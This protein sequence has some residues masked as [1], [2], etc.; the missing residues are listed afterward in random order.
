MAQ[1]TIAIQNLFKQWLWNAA[2][3]LARP[4]MTMNARFSN[5]PKS[6]KHLPGGKTNDEKRQSFAKAAEFRFWKKK[7]S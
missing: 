7:Q 4:A 6:P 3:K 2:L 1:Q 5:P